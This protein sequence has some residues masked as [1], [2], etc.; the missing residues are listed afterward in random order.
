[1]SRRMRRAAWAGWL[2]LASVAGRHY[3]AGPTVDA[4]VD[5]CRRTARQGFAGAICYWNDEADTPQVVGR[6][7]LE[8]VAALERADLDCY[9]S[10]K[11]TAVGYA[12][13]LMGEIGA[14]ASAAGFRLHLDSM[15]PESAAPTLALL[16]ELAARRIALG[17]TLPGRWRRSVDDAER[18]IE[19]G[20]TVRVV[21]GQWPDPDHPALD[22]SAG[23]LAVIDR[24]AGRA[25]LV[26][27]ATHD[28]C[29]A[30]AA[31]QRLRAAG[32]ACE[33]EL[34]FGLPRRAVVPLARA[35][36]VP[37]R[38]YVPYGAAWV[39]YCLSQVRQNP[40]LL[41]WAV[42][43]AALSAS[44]DLARLGARSR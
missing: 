10:L 19:L 41:W 42:R 38:I 37:A 35:A 28:P 26:A 7:Y 6:H 4:A 31:L 40:R 32:T 2:S 12:R 8:A 25:P 20:L 22:P 17:C 3:V 1:M 18:A 33:L 27:V 5:T 14:R 43:D 15:W 21:K 30:L 34:L 44:S 29:L 23:F 13:E 39:P 16:T 36:H 11:A 9:L 24:L